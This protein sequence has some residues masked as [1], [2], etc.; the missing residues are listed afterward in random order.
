M[1]STQIA[2]DSPAPGQ[3]I[4]RLAV[5]PG[6]HLLRAYFVALMR[7]QMGDIRTGIPFRLW[8]G[9]FATHLESGRLVRDH[10]NGTYFLSTGG[11]AYFT[12]GS[13]APKPAMLAGFLHA[14]VSG[15]ESDLPDGLASTELVRSGWITPKPFP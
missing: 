15:R 6:G 7:L 14:L 5:P 13:S 9:N 8:R 2:A 11:V 4:W 3:E 1:D 12:T 10:G